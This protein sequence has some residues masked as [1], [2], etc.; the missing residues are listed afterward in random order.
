MA[1]FM[2]DTRGIEFVHARR[3]GFLLFPIAPP[4]PASALA[5]V[6]SSRIRP[7]R[8]NCDQVDPTFG[9]LRGL[10]PQPKRFDSQKRYLEVARMLKKI[11][12]AHGEI[13]NDLFMVIELNEILFPPV[14]ACNRHT[15][16]DEW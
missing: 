7:K 15:R 1:S 12:T 3:A 2:E 8:L 13:L 10:G 5:K 9:Y 16:F 6:P 11:V 14:R 4:D